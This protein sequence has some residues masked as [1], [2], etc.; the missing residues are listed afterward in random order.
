MKYAELSKEQKQKLLLAALVGV[1][2][3]YALVSFVIHP[4]VMSGKRAA[5]EL[6]ALS[7]RVHKAHLAL[8]REAQIRENLALSHAALADAAKSHIPASDNPLSWVAQRVYRG[9][10]EVGVEIESVV[11]LGVTPAAWAQSD[12]TGRA[13]RPYTVRIVTQCSY[14]GLVNLIR[15]LEKSNPY[16]CVSEIQ[17]A[18]QDGD[19]E[20]HRISLSVEWPVWV[21]PEAPHELLTAPGE[22]HG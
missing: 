20:R 2:A 8:R 5:G 9:A 3:L 13:F 10:R 15:T 18:A 6:E 17:I 7:A 22:S 21:D 14:R 1:G 12:A 11:D 16:L 4:F 19:V